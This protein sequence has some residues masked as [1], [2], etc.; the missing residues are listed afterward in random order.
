MEDSTA[1][2][3]RLGDAQAYE[4]LRIHNALI[5]DCLRTHEGTEVTHTGDGIEASFRFASNAI[6][7]AIAI[8]RAFARYNAEHPSATIRVRVGINAGEPI[9]T[10]G[11]LF[12]T[13]VHTAFRICTRARPGQILL[14]DIVRRLT[15]GR[16]FVFVNRG[17]VILKG[18]QQRVHLYE[19]RWADAYERVGDS[20]S[21][22]WVQSTT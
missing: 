14:S 22:Y 13:A 5:R 16:S 2:I 3:D 17:R 9:T 19:V 4:L 20:R 1:L 8:Q 21:A 18:F 7:C 12:G 11:R 6:E 10:E 15:V